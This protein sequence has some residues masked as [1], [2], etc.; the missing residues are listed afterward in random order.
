MKR[1]V[2][3]ALGLLLLAGCG[4]AVAPDEPAG[5]RVI[6]EW[7][8]HGITLTYVEEGTILLRH[9]IEEATFSGWGKPWFDNGYVSGMAFHDFDGDGENE[10]AV[11]E[12]VMLG[13]A[14]SMQLHM[15]K[16]GGQPWIDHVFT[17]EDA[18]AWL[19]TQGFA[20]EYMSVDF[21]MGMRVMLGTWEAD[22]VYVADVSFDGTQFQL[23][24]ITYYAAGYA[25]MDKN[26]WED[27]SEREHA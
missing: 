26:P 12:Q 10:L 15:I 23:S 24:D 11:I 20:A 21:N 1:I 19:D 5:P 27:L 18:A 17:V 3:L 22:S 4:R 8:E 7:P 25:R 16:L 2:A 9:G 14:P 6:A 13:D